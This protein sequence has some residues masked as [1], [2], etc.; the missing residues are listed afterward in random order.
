MTSIIVNTRFNRLARAARQAGALAV[1]ALVVG[2]LA[3]GCGTTHAPASAGADPAAAA[4]K[5]SA[6]P[7]PTVTGGTV[8]T[9]EPACAGWPADATRGTLTAFFNPVAVE[10]C[11]TGVQNG[12]GKVE[13]R[14][15]TLEKATK[16]LTPLVAA[17]LRPSAQHEPGIICPELAMLPPQ[18]VLISSAGKKLIPRLPLSA[19]GL[20]QSGVLRV[21]ATL[22][23][24]P[25][26]VRL[27]TKLTGSQPLGATPRVS[28]PKTI[29]TLPVS[30]PPNQ[31]VKPVSS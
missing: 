16:D 31:A 14:T 29:M 22:S 21:L 27:I 24:E 26:S 12:P 9:G 20:A 1:P 6:T 3:A 4:P 28:S 5:V 23:W 15:A 19:C 2:A 11:V 18:V 10:R 8:I 30:V 25:I 13:W 17:L 7:V